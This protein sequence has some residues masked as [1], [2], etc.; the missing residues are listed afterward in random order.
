MVMPRS[1]GRGCSFLAWPRHPPVNYQRAGFMQIQSS[2][3]ATR[4]VIVRA[5]IEC[6]QKRGEDSNLMNKKR[7]GIDVGTD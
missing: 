2:V 6:E 7:Q 3:P 1:A 5:D 4:P